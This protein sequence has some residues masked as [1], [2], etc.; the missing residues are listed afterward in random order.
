MK[1]LLLLL[2]I[3]L[4]AGIVRSTAQLANFSFS[5]T[6]TVSGWTRV[7]GDPATGAQTATMNGITVSSIGSSNWSPDSEPSDV[8]QNTGAANGTYFPAAVMASAWY[9]WN[10]NTNNLALYNA[11]VPQL[12]LSGLNRD[13]TYT[14]RMSSRCIYNRGVTQYTVAGRSVA[15][16]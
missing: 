8:A 14:L 13:S 5:T 15:G 4:V 2:F 6:T 9:S 12:K 10:G 16:S 3:L 1:R 7:S 11:A